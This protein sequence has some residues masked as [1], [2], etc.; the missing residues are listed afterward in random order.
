MD[1]GTVSQTMTLLSWVPQYTQV[2]A[3]LSSISTEN[4]VYALIPI[5]ICVVGVHLMFKHFF[6][7]VWLSTKVFLALVL[8]IQIRDVVATVLE[9]DPLSIEY[10]LFGL[11]TGT[12]EYTRS[13][14]VGVI[15]ARVLSTLM[16][17]GWFAMFMGKITQP[18]EDIPLGNENARGENDEPSYGSWLAFIQDSFVH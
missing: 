15:K 9:K 2:L 1:T 6:S 13:I 18:V 17:M 12:L 3:M 10:R 4:F 8:Y 11:P 5:L 16:N 7:L 14:G